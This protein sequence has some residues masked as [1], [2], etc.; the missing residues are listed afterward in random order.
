M[1]YRRET[2]IANVSLTSISLYAKSE[3]DLNRARSMKVFSMIMSTLQL[4]ETYNSVQFR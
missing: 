1:L 4:Y 3:E 2:E